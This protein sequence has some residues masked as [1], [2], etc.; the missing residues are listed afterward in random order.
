MGVDLRQ[1]KKDHF[2]RYK[3][4]PRDYQRTNAITSSNECIGVFYA[5]DVSGYTSNLST[6]N[7]R[8]ARD[9]TR[10]V[11]ETYDMIK[12][13]ESGT[14]LY[15]MQYKTWWVVENYVEDSVNETEQNSTRPSS[16]KEI[17]IRKG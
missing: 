8:F 1:G 15:N 6:F 14:I 7:N 11:I 5:K 16:R 12:P 10:G 9:T 4:Y 13:L 2:V 3:I 17:T